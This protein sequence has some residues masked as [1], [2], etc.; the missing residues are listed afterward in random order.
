MSA[1]RRPSLLATVPFRAPELTVAV[2]VDPKTLQPVAIG[3]LAG[4]AGSD[5]DAIARQLAAVVNIALARGA[6]IEE[7]RRGLPVEARNAAVAVPLAPAMLD[8]AQ[9]QI[10]AARVSLG[11]AGL[12]GS[13][14]AAT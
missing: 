5:L 6:S 2:E 7:I 9:V 12:M 13:A 4:M 10:E 1:Q 3:V 14:D 11:S 8:A